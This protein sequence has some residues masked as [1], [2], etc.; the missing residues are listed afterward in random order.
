MIWLRNSY[1][2]GGDFNSYKTKVDNLQCSCPYAFNIW[3]Q[4]YNSV[5]DGLGSLKNFVSHNYKEELC[6]T[7]IIYVNKE[8]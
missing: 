3:P 2:I 7:V 1:K 6:W 4:Y 5:T 8:K